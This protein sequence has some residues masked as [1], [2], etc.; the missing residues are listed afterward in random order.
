[1]ILR[2]LFLSVAL[3]SSLAAAPLDETDPRVTWLSEHAARLR[4]S[5]IADVD[6]SDLAPIGKAIGDARVVM[7][8]EQS[9]GDGATFE[10]RAR[11]IRYLHE[12]LGFDV[13]AFESGMWDCSVMNSKLAGDGDVAP[14]LEQGLFSIWTQSQQ[15]RAFFEYAKETHAGD[16]PLELAGC[17]IQ[18][19]GSAGQTYA[20]DVVKEIEA[21]QG[22]KLDAAV[23]AAFLAAHARITTS[24]AAPAP[25]TLAPDQAAV[26]AFDRAITEK[27]A[28]YAAALGER[29]FAFLRRT[30]ANFR[31]ELE[32]VQKLSNRERE[33]QIAGS[34]LRDRIMGE[35]VVWLANEHYRG[36]KMIV[37]SAARHLAHDLN[38]LAPRAGQTQPEPKF[39]TLGDPVHAALGDAAYTIFFTAYSGEAGICGQP[40]N[41]VAPAAEGTLEDLLHKTGAAFA[42]VDL[43]GLR[44]DAGHWL[45]APIGA[46]PFGYAS[47]TGPWAEVCDAFLF[48]DRMYKST[49]AGEKQD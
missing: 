3:A 8:G 10:T 47:R 9:H 37:W 32:L 43:R 12:E 48:T 44:G 39:V 6:F 14:I 13:V 16:R 1:M 49:V 21:V 11:V 20:A 17:D 42:F 38:Q 31:A 18:F 41:A 36:K 35:N 4:S 40:A 2:M 24:E 34:N 25:E 45:N 29:R 27:D 19:S 30:L 7:I 26:D 23:K 33:S 5:D 28:P 46:R 22:A 15:C